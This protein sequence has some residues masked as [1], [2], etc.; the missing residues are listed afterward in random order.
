MQ[1]FPDLALVTKKN[2]VPDLGPVWDVKNRGKD[3]AESDQ[4][5]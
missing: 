2:A 5:I 1:K 3:V 4:S